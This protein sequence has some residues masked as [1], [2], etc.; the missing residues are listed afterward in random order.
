MLKALVI[1]ESPAKAKTI[2][3]YLGK[4]FKVMASY[5]HVRDLVPK[6]GAVDPSHDFAMRYQVVE[7]NVRHMDAI[8]K[9]LKTCDTLYLATDPDREGEA[10][11]W[12]VQAL[13]LQQKSF[14][15]KKF[16]RIVFHQ[17]TQKAVQEAMQHPRDILMDLVNA[18]QARRALD[19]LVGFTLSPLLWKKVRPGLSAGRVQSPAL[20]MIV[21][22]DIEIAHFKTQEYWTLHAD[23]EAQQQ[24]FS[25]RLIEY[26]QHKIEQFSMVNEAK[27]H[28]VREA[29]IHAARGQLTVVR[30]VKK[31]RKRHPAMP[32]I[33]S[34]LQ[35]EA[36]RKLGFSASQAMRI[37]QQLYEGVD[38]GTEGPVGLI[39]YMRTDSVILAQEALED[40]RTLIAKKYGVDNVPKEPR[41]Y[42]TKSKN[43]QEAHEAIRPTT[44]SFVPEDLK[45]YLT[46][47]QLKLYGLIWKR[48]I[49]CQ[50][51]DALLNTVAIDLSSGNAL[52]R[53][54][55]STIV[56][57]GFITV[58]QEGVDDQKTE[59]RD[60]TMLPV[61]EEGEKIAVDAI[62][63][64][65][66]FTDPPPRYTE[67]SLVKEL[68]AND[69]GRPSTY[70]SIMA[71]L[72]Q[73]EYVVIH[74]KRFVA[75]DVGQVV[76]RF[77]KDYFE[78]YV[79][80]GFTAQLED[81]LDA[82]ARGETH[83][84]PVLTKFWEP[85]KKLIDVTEKTVQRSDVTQE[86]MDENCPKCEAPLSTRLGR[87]GRFVG[88]T[89]YP[90][91]DY[92]RN[93]NESA[94]AEI[95]EVIEGR[96]C[97]TCGSDLVIKSGKYG[98]FIGC[99]GYPKCRHI[100][101]LEKPKDTGVTC[102][103]CKKHLILERKSRRK[104]IFYS[105]AGYPNC[106]YALWG[107][108]IAES[109]PKC[110]WPIL[111]IKTTQRSGR[112]KICPQRSCDFKEPMPD[113]IA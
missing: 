48:T 101:P 95:A 24:K 72:Q 33:T 53:A 12:H 25:A 21:E 38:V 41:F 86:K 7:R 111:S 30:V 36:V 17:I 110:K 64:E 77:L 8:K 16:A 35:Q 23:L 102:P 105:C 42:K 68:E 57:P 100:E 70:A 58:Y 88:C 79:D 54:N 27:A 62:R 112:E 29:I 31:E 87:R 44:A 85:F 49:A 34:T 10:I 13:L 46:R 52:F 78:K 96:V 71:T 19:Y 9:I 1:V 18:Q 103:K 26:D 94:D 37:A 91:C 108:P 45:P 3:K 51:V 69:I 75:T 89:A 99:S 104:K 43:A 20:R 60:P 47:D 65:Q 63:A 4:S 84:T 32:F 56:K 82:I 66:H 92:T 40:I 55:G 98:K 22:R 73:R 76:T 90:D 74:T 97:P 28:E 67:A 2:E 5:G 11:A 39:T 59:D 80:Y 83:Y 50:M 81:E 93:L 14:A 15:K 106:Q 61:L 113:D 109:C 6:E 107:L